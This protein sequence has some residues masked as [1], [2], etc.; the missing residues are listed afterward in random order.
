VRGLVLPEISDDFA[1]DPVE[2]FFDLAYVFAFSQLVALILADSTWHGIGEASL[3]FLLLWMPWSQFTWSANAVSGNSRTVRVLFLV[4]T[5]ASVPMAAAIGTALDGSGL[6]FALPLATI[7]LMALSM[8]VSGLETGSAEYRSTLRYATP[9]VIAMTLVVLG[10]FVHD[11]ARVGVWVAG[12]VVFGIGTLRAGSDEWIVRTGHFAERHGLI[13]IIA[14]GEVIVALGNSIVVSGGDVAA[15]TV[16]TLV[17]A[18]V[19][20]SLLWWSYFD[21]VQPAFEHRAESLSGVARGKFVRD[22]YTYGHIPLV[23]GIVLIAVSLEKMTLHPTDPLAFTYRIIGAAGLTMFFG[24]IGISVFR[25]FHVVAKE[26]VVAV[27]I[28][29]ALMAFGARLDGVTLFVAIDVVLLVAL[30]AEHLRIEPPVRATDRS[31]T[32]TA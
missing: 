15:S 20:A 7:F 21:R 26:R 31:A 6:L 5:A 17:A 2:L 28:V 30:V 12:I 18:G 22:I 11:G 1:A 29:I 14:L 9:S 16:V 19:L 25:S 3:L 27:A 13:V 23:A 32:S 24:G 10:A 4:A 8:L